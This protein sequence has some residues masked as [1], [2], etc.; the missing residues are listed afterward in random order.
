MDVTVLPSAPF[1]QETGF[2]QSGAAAL[3]NARLVCPASG[4]DGAGGVLIE[5]GVIVGSGPEFA[6]N[7]PASAQTIDCQGALLCPGLIDMQTFTGEPGEEH[8]ETLASAS[9]AAA[10]G[11]VTTIICMPNTHP[12]IDDVA[13]VDFI[14]RRA[15]DTALVNI[16]PMAAMTKGLQGREMS[17]I[18][19]LKA[20]GA[21]A[22]SNGKR[23]VQNAQTMRLLLTYARDF[24]ALVVHHVEDA[25]MGACGVMNEGDVSARL[26]LSGVSSAAETIMLERDIRLVSLACGRYHAAAI[27]CADSLEVIRKAKGLGLPVTCSVPINNLTL[28]ENDIGSYRTYFKLRPPLR[29][30]DDRQALVEGV[31]S[32][33]IDVI[34]SSHDPQDVDLKR[35][36]FAE[37]ADGAIGLETLFPAALQLFHDGEVD[38][39]VLIRAMSLRPAEI[40]GLPGG[41]LV[42]GAP[43]DL[44]L[45]DMRAPWRVDSKLFYSKCRNSPFD[46]R[47]LQGK[48]LKTF[49]AGRCVYDYGSARGA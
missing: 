36:P 31:R 24:D 30:E 18:G 2:R 15:R 49:V 47:V 9:K 17:E 26:G 21:V 1:R 46:E 8:R 42:P 3:I 13:L 39:P 14:K 44:T 5:N 35:R 37:A 11:G 22:F 23:S 33:D 7:A 29:R 12:V 10:A 19:L 32:G 45:M 27:S 28:N 40:L 4:Y 38:L 34:V 25:D 20:A 16:H 48:V 43:A 6:V 41:R